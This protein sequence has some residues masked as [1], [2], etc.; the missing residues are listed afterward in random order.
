[1]QASEKST[2]LYNIMGTNAPILTKNAVSLLSGRCHSVTFPELTLAAKAWP[3]RLHRQLATK[4]CQ[5][6]VFLPKSTSQ[7][8]PSK[9]S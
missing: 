7:F 5:P 9:A 2:F 3:C 4:T 8:H 1:M 6:Q